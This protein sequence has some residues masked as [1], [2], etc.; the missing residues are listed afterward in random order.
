MSVPI[1]Q[2]RL[3]DACPPS[4]ADDVNVQAVCEALDRQFRELIDDINQTIIL[5]AID[6]ITDDKL[7]DLLAWQLHVDFYDA[8]APVALKQLVIK[9]SLDWH[10]RKGTV[11][12]IQ[13]VCDQ[14][15][16]PGSAT[17][18]EWFEYKIPFPPNYP[19]ETPDANGWNWHDRYRFRILIDQ[20]VIDPVA[21]A[22][23]AQIVRAYKPLTRWDEGIIRARRS[24]LEI[25]WAAVSLPWKYVTSEAPALGT[26]IV[27]AINPPSAVPGAD[28]S[29]EV[30]GTNF[31]FLASFIL[32][33][34][35]F[36]Q[37]FSIVNT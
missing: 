11:Q 10:T 17:V 34:I 3:I 9:S 4:I 6:T 36:L 26:P 12:L 14:F 7:L 32:M 15:F 20:E 19:D 22:R 21:E 23:V 27:N 5:P 24:D 13:D 25:W 18:Q 1:R 35:Q 30:I 16:P 29:L 28:I 37:P 8:A 2:S 31:F 33:A